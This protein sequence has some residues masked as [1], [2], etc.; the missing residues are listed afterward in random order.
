MHA[1]MCVHLKIKTRGMRKSFKKQLT[2]IQYHNAAYKGSNDLVAAWL[3]TVRFIFSSFNMIKSVWFDLRAVKFEKKKF[4]FKCYVKF[5]LSISFLI[6]LKMWL[7]FIK[8]F[9]SVDIFVAKS[10]I[11]NILFDLIVGGTLF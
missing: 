3:T 4:D 11:A 7:L 2:H 5:L 6:A 10:G 1:G 8:M 9:S